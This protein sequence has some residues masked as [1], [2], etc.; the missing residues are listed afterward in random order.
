MGFNV[1]S[2][3]IRVD[4]CCERDIALHMIA[5]DGDTRQRHINPLQ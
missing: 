1:V 4:A 2:E 3:F 5:V